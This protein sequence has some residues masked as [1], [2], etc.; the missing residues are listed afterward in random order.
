MCVPAGLHITSICVPRL[1]P[2]GLF[3]ICEETYLFEISVNFEMY[4]TC[5]G[6]ILS[7]VI[8][9]AGVLVAIK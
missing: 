2:F 3:R 7:Q 1:K 4:L 6:N 8:L 9:P 5:H